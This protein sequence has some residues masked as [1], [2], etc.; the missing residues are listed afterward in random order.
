MTSFTCDCESKYTGKTTQQLAERIRQHIP[1]GLINVAGTLR[2][3]L[4]GSIVMAL[5]VEEQQTVAKGL[6]DSRS[7]SSITRGLKIANSVLNTVCSSKV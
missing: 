7:D 5:S 3:V 4:P 2:K 6:A 1:P